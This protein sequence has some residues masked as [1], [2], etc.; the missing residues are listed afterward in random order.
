MTGADNAPT[1]E[2]AIGES[3]TSE[4]HKASLEVQD[5]KSDPKSPDMDFTAL[6]QN[7]DHLA[8]G[9][10]RRAGLLYPSWW[11][12]TGSSSFISPKTATSA[13]V[14][15]LYWQRFVHA[16]RHFIK[17]YLH[18]SFT[19]SSNGLCNWTAINTEAA[20][21]CEYSLLV[22]AFMLNYPSTTADVILLSPSY[23]RFPTCQ[24]LL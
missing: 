3:T 14:E 5:K 13:F 16:R 9:R 19:A 4:I 18:A 22:I 20:R 21:H 24:R 10:L 1:N 11:K 17:S 7:I 12:Q 8:Y 23:R 6:Q 15:H 2:G